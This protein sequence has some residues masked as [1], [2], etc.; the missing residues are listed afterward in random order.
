MT[1]TGSLFQEL[2]ELNGPLGS[3]GVPS[4]R[5]R[6]IFAYVYSRAATLTP[7]IDG[8]TDG[9]GLAQGQRVASIVVR[10]SGRVPRSF[11]LHSV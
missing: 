7:L 6:A 8:I 11:L 1:T 5:Y 9:M 3:R 2:G 10:A 4:R